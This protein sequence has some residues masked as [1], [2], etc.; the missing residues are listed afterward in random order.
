MDLAIGLFLLFATFAVYAQVRN[1]AFVNFDDPDYVSGNAHV[2]G[3][4][5]LDSIRWA[6]TSGQAANWFPVTRLS[7]IIDVQFFGLNSGLHHLTS[8]LIH[9]LAA[10]ALFAFLKRA[11]HA[12][13]P[14]AFVAFLFA[15]HPMHVESVAWIAERKDVMSALFWFLALWAYVFYTEKPGVKRYLLVLVPFCLGLMAKPMIVTL[16]LTLLLLDFWPLDRWR[17]SRIVWEKI[18]LFALSGA[19][20][21]I[22]L[23]VQQSSGAVQSLNAF[24]LGLRIEN[25]LVSYV[26]YIGKTF[27]PSGM[28]VFYPFPKEIPAWEALLAALALAGV[29]IL[30]VRAFRSFPFLAVGW[31]WY[32]IT[33]APVIGLVQAGA[34]A[35]ADRYTYVPMI[36][37]AI[38]LAWGAAAV[39]A[40]WPRAKPAVLA[41][42]G[43]GCVCCAAVTWFQL[44]YWRDSETLFRHAL[45][46]TSGNYLAHHNLGVTLSD[47]GNFAEAISQYQA[48]LQI[49]PD[50]PNVQ[51]DYG[52]ALARWGR[53]SEA[54]AHYQA[55]LRVLPDSPITHNDLANAY[56]ATPGRMPE[57]IAEYQTALRLK[58]DYEEAR[59]NLAQVLSNAAEIEYNLGVELAKGRNPEAAI[60]HFEEALRLKPDYVD[61]HNNLGVV[62]A[63]TG[64]VE[65]AISHFE[66]ALRIDPNSAD[67]HVNLGIALSQVPGRTPDAIRH[68]EAALRI[69]PD[70]E[71]QHT[72]DHLEKE[73]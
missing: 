1:F 57:A 12:R 17:T 15:L 8:V 11:T 58:P 10:L 23:L 22:T 68:L 19:G 20:V 40:R 47:K 65:E 16:P 5:T 51:T 50:A 9:A 48:A 4:L 43:A 34:Q 61:A 46:V 18:P 54:I 72:L 49:E 55:A 24:P 3:G 2:R 7:H 71:I 26:V 41:V 37:L 32:L 69:K 39:V 45:D 63:G 14:S 27:W 29:S 35:R 70:P 62:L 30:V 60:P 66:T 64:R 6:L 67:A 59:K 56:A 25:A 53:T 73:R 36:G 28:A 42:A 21:L 31:L 33:L 13:W 52:N 38:M 44:Q